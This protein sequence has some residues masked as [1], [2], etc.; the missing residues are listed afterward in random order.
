MG[1]DSP[2]HPTQSLPPADSLKKNTALIFR[3]I[4]AKFLQINKR[5]TPR[6]YVV[7]RNIICIFVFL[8]MTFVPIFGQVPKSNPIPP[9]EYPIIAGSKIKSFFY[10]L[11]NGMTL[12][13]IPDDRNPMAMMRFMLNAGSNQEKTGNTGLAHFFEHMMF[14]MTKDAPEG[15][16]DRVLSSVGGSGNAGTSD[17]FVTFY[18][19]FPAPALKTMVQLESQRF[20]SLKLSEP[21][22]STEKGA[23]LSERKLRL[24]NDVIQRAQTDLNAVIQKGTPL[25]WPTIGSKKDVEN[26]SLKEARK[27]Y[28][29]FYTP[30]NTT[31]IIGGPFSPKEVYQIVN[32][33]FSSWH[34]PYHKSLLKLPPQYPQ[35]LYQ[36]N[37]V[38]SAKI[39]QQF[40]DITYPS[41][42]ATYA[43]TVY[44]DIFSAI[45]NDSSGGTFQRRLFKKN[46]AV[47]F[48]AYKNYWGTV[49][50]F[51]VLFILNKNQKIKPLMELWKRE[52]SRVLKEGIS[53]KIKDQLLRQHQMENADTAEK[54]SRLLSLTLENYYFFHKKTLA[55]DYEK[56]LKA[57]TNR[58]LQEW[59]RKN[60]SP[61]RFY[62]SALTN[63]TKYAPC[64]QMSQHEEKGEKNAQK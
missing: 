63:D 10:Q 15:N 44:A 33:F 41:R 53:D 62:V 42:I 46:K 7:R 58:K 1:D 12:I 22:F 20:L 60:L 8:S 2:G 6:G 47:N 29:K 48:Y 28:E 24:E 59:I 30:K 19:S 27:F 50:P 37:F 40:Y 23:V 5:I 45:L 35:N 38:C 49:K 57:A 32:K 13:V 26:M 36:K 18:S 52:I 11:K 39:Q 55:G 54:M 9:E 64:T 43:D 17:S 61:H 4:T 51:E 21:Y 14:R 16:Y 25:Q 34:R 3:L 56:I 31:L